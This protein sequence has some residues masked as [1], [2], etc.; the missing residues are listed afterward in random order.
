MADYAPVQES[1]LETGPEPSAGVV[2]NGQGD[3]GGFEPVNDNDMA[4]NG[5]P[6]TPERGFRGLPYSQG[7]INRLGNGNAA[8]R[9]IGKAI[10]GLSSYGS[11]LN[12]MNA[13]DFE[14]I[15]S[16]M[17]ATDTAGGGTSGLR[18]YGQ[19][20]LNDVARV[21]NSVFAAV[22]TVFTAISQGAGQSAEEIK[23]GTGQSVAADTEH[24]LNI[25]TT[26]AGINMMLLGASQYAEAT[27]VVKTPSGGLMDQRIGPVP[28]HVE[29]AQQAATVATH[30]GIP[31]AAPAIT[32]AYQKG[33][34]PAEIFHDAKTDPTILPALVEGKTP[35]VYPVQDWT[36][37]S[38]ASE[39]AAATGQ[40]NATTSEASDI[41]ASQ[42]V[43]G[44]SATPATPAGKLPA[45]APRPV[46]GTG[47]LKA[48]GLS[49]STEAAAINNELSEG[50]ANLPTYQAVKDTDQG[51]AALKFLNDDPEAAMDVAMG[52]K[53]APRG[54]LPEAA[55]VAVKNKAV[56]EGD[57][58]TLRNLATQSTLTQQA[59][60][61]G[62]RISYLRNVNPEN[63]PVAAIQQVQE[64][65]S[66]AL[67]AKGVDVDKAIGDE[68]AQAQQITR[69]ARAPQ[70]G[71]WDSFIQSITCRE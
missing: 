54:L 5:A 59:T 66:A 23:P 64:A 39:P 28:D 49:E 37:Q 32:E 29:A 11:N 20:L 61:M 41:P 55:Y 56:A 53:A 7:A 18:F 43:I 47:E 48:R 22:P 31:D 69:A 50:F 34:L 40:K 13:D 19:A 68:V 12:S 42:P 35:E 36:G 52:R 57:V 33:V 16:F 38:A 4:P 15:R 17:G 70:P 67:K 24:N 30:Y 44:Q 14:T 63:D 45:G 1:E 26:D 2:G 21:K 46:A 62:Q 10:E 65:R 51:A 9:V 60:T 25:F 27:R 71:A 8:T 3:L 58:E 6:G